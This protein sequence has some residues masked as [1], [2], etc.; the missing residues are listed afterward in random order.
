ML[1]NE[2]SNKNSDV[3]NNSAANEYYIVPFADVL[4][5]TEGYQ[6]IL[7]M[8]GVSKENCNIKIDNDELIVTGKKSNGHKNYE[9]L[10]NEIFYSGFNRRFIIPND[11][12]TDKINANLENGVLK[13]QLHKKEELKPKEILIS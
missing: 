8:P 7:D 1:N 11:I 13:L 2:K 12:D 3:A 6:I 4:A 5:N 10:Y 9:H